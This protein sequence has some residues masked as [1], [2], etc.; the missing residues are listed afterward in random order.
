M[1]ESAL[2]EETIQNQKVQPDPGLLNEKPN[3]VLFQDAQIYQ[4]NH[5]VISNLDLEIEEGAFIYLVGKTGSG[6]SSLLRTIYGEIPL[7][8]G[9]GEVAGFDLRKLRKSRVYKLRR[10]L[11]MVFQDFN[12]LF[13]RSVEANLMFVLR[14]TGWKEGKQAQRRIEEVLQSVG[15]RYQAHKMP[16]ELSGGER[17][18][19]AIARAL[20]NEPELLIADE[21]TGNLDPDTSDE[22]LKLIYTL[23]QE[24]NTTVLLATHDYRLIEQYPARVYRCHGGRLVK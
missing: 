5:L 24:K 18:R 1:V 17:Q 12:L 16:H 20:L 3:V 22:I 15:L 21:P 9:I 7:M 23:N 2:I 14:A 8:H 19:V 11:G 10:K 13:D 4:N 6:K